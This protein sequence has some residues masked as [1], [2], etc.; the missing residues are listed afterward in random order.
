VPEVPAESATVAT[1]RRTRV[2]SRRARPQRRHRSPVPIR[3]PLEGASAGMPS[4]PPQCRGSEWPRDST[5]A[6]AGWG[7]GAASVATGAAGAEGLSGAFTA[8]L[9]PPPGR[10]RMRGQK[11]G[12]GRNPA[13]ARRLR[14]CRRRVAVVSQ[15][16]CALRRMTSAG[17]PLKGL[18]LTHFPGSG[19]RGH[20]HNPHFR[21]PRP[22]LRRSI[23]PRRPRRPGTPGHPIPGR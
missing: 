4:P 5:D 8:A 9:V 10:A 6:T 23:P 15:C 21:R 13:A 7:S 2:S 20:P 16:R 14:T 11:A 19:K 12:A 22:T 18:P 3:A 1:W 17:S